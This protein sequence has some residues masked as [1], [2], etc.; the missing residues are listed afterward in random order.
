MRKYKYMIL[1]DTNNKFYVRRIRATRHE[2]DTD[3]VVYYADKPLGN[4]LT[5]MEAIKVL[6]KAS[7][8]TRRKR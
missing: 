4:D 7:G 1:L 2:L 6:N 3:E 5:L 8:R